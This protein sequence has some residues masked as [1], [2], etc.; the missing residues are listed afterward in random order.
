MIRWFR[1]PNGRRYY[2]VADPINGERPDAATC[3]QT[4]Q[5]GRVQRIRLGVGVLNELVEVHYEEVP[6]IW[7]E[8]FRDWF[9]RERA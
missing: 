3:M 2:A 9:W 8:A 1:T 5:V 7:R 4:Q 6:K